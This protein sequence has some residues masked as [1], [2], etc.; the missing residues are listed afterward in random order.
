M[1]SKL[2]SFTAGEI[3]R[4]FSMRFI[5][6]IPFKLSTAAVVVI[7]VGAAADVD[8]VIVVVVCDVLDQVCSVQKSSKII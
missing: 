1:I 2:N 8:D 6:T 7:D 4:R 5:D 3:E